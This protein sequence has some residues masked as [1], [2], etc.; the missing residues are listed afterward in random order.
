MASAGVLS[1]LLIKH[2][3]YQYPSDRIGLFVKYSNKITAKW[4]IKM[5]SD[6]TLFVSKE[7]I[8]SFALTDSGCAFKS[9]FWRKAQLMNVFTLKLNFWIFICATK[10]AKLIKLFSSYYRWFQPRRKRW[11]CVSAELHTTTIQVHEKQS[12]KFCLS[13]AKNSLSA[14]FNEHFWSE[15]GR[16]RKYGDLILVCFSLFWRFNWMISFSNWIKMQTDLVLYENCWLWPTSDWLRR[17]FPLECQCRWQANRH[18]HRGMHTQIYFGV[19]QLSMCVCALVWVNACACGISVH[20][21]E[22]MLLFFYCCLLMLL[23]PL[24]RSVSVF[25]FHMG[26]CVHVCVRMDFFWENNCLVHSFTV[27]SCIGC[28]HWHNDFTFHRHE[29][30]ILI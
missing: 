22:F 6:D 30:I 17:A 28:G 27:Q 11:F 20:V 26:V 15:R 18:A 25:M 23:L 7:R 13:N 1:I 2:S 12:K 21:Y 14:M 24:P 10:H 29:F 4:Q 16:L 5:K 19:F 3:T 8:N 9:T